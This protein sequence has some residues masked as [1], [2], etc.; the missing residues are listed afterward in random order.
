MKSYSAIIALIAAGIISA[1]AQSTVELDQLKSAM[2]T[3]QKNMEDMQKKID[4]LEAEK[5]AA[6]APGTNA[7]GGIMFAPPS[8][9]SHTAFEPGPRPRQLERPAGGGATIE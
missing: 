3:M 6:A 7:P 1:P 5:G 9:T 8:R 2:Q 4:E